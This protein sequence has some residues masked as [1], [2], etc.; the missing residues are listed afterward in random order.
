MPINPSYSGSGSQFKAGPGK[1]HRT[2]SE[3]TLIKKGCWSSSVIEHLPPVPPKEKKKE[4][5]KTL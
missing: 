2:L 1:K 5:K 4:K 3:E